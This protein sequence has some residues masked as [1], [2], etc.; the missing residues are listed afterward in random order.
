MNSPSEQ[1]VTIAVDGAQQVSGLLQ[2]PSPAR[3]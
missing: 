1:L 3:A 2:L